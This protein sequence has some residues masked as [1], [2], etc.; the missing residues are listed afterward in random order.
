MNTFEVFKLYPIAIDSAKGLELTDTE[1]KKYL[2]LY[3]GHGVISIGHCQED[4][5]K[6]LKAQLDKIGFYSNSVRIPYQEELAVKLQEL[7]GYSD[8]KLFLVNSGAEANENALKLASFY[9]NRSKVIA[10]RHAFHGRTSLAVAVTDSPAIQAPINKTDKVLWAEL[11]DIES[12][13]AVMDN[14]VAAVIIEG[15]QGVGGVKIPTDDFL[16]QLRELCTANGSLLIIDEIQCGYGRTGKFFYHQYSG[17]KA[18]IIS[19]AKG[20]A[21]GFP[22]GAIMINPEIP[23]KFG[24]LG[25]TFG[26]N[27]LG[28]MAALCTAEVMMKN[29]YVANAA[30]MGEY[31][32]GKL[33][34]HK[35]I[36]ELR[37]K[38]LMIGIET[39]GDASEIRNKLLFDEHIFTGFSG[40][41]N[42]IRLIPP[43]CITEKEIDR[44][45][46]AFD[47]VTK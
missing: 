3:G 26:G 45:V 47:K 34:G 25:T 10:F 22:V 39:V 20:I 21:N 9:T 37:G 30:K 7:S 27:H 14:D 1:G 29:N 18:D 6:G 8:Y 43:L 19:M 23:A 17:I 5:V 36:K 15:I 44:F 32:F 41:V 33:K 31:I 28:C 12:V 4:Y 16:R 35:A 38:G 46:E 40:G 2:D 13:K 42:T 24:M 11:N